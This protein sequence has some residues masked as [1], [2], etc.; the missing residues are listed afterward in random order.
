METPAGPDFQMVL[1]LTASAVKNRAAAME[2]KGRTRMILDG[3]A[4]GRTRDA[5]ALM[6]QLTRWTVGAVPAQPS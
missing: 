4:D 1:V 5:T 6:N 2:C 3:I